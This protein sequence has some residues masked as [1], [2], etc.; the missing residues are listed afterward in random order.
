[1]KGKRKAARMRSSVM[2]IL[3]VL[4]TVLSI[5]GPALALSWD[6]TGVSSGGS[7]MTGSGGYVLYESEA[8]RATVA[9]RFSAIRADGSYTTGKLETSV[10]E[11][12]FNNESATSSNS[13]NAIKNKTIY[14]SETKYDKAAIVRNFLANDKTTVSLPFVT[15]QNDNQIV[16]EENIDTF[17]SDLPDD[18][19]A[20]GAWFAYQ[21]NADTVAKMLGYKSGTKEM[22]LG[23]TIIV[24]PVFQLV[25]ENQWH[26]LTVTEIAAYAGNK[27]GSFSNTV[28]TSSNSQSWGFICN[29]TNKHWPNALRTEENE[30]WWKNAPKLTDTTYGSRYNNA[31]FGTLIEKGYGVGILWETN[32]ITT[33]PD[34]GITPF[35]GTSYKIVFA[36]D[37][38]HIYDPYKLPK[39][40]DI[41]VIVQV[42]D[43]NSS[44]L[45]ESCYFYFEQRVHDER[46]PIMS[47]MKRGRIVTNYSIE[48]QAFVQELTGLSG[49]IWSLDEYAQANRTPHGDGAA[50]PVTADGLP[51]FWIDTINS[52]GL[53]PSNWSGDYGVA[54][55]TLDAVEPADIAALEYTDTNNGAVQSYR[56]VDDAISQS[57]I[58]ITDI[59]L[60]ASMSTEN[61]FPKDAG[62]VYKIPYGAK[63]YVLH[64]YKNHSSHTDWVRGFDKSTSST[65]TDR[66]EIAANSETDYVCA[67]RFIADHANAAGSNAFTAN[68]RTGYVY[69]SG[70]TSASH[71]SNTAN[72]SRSVQWK[73]DYDVAAFVIL[74]DAAG[75]MLG[76]SDS[77]KTIVVP[78]GQKVYVYL[79][80]RNYM[81]SSLIY[82]SGSSQSKLQISGY[83]GTTASTA[84]ANASKKTVTQS[85]TGDSN[86]LDIQYTSF[87]AAAGGSG[88]YSFS[89]RV[90]G[91][92][93]DSGMAYDRNTANNSATLNYTVAAP[94]TDISLDSIYYTTDAAGNNKFTGTP[95]FNVGT[96]IYIWYT[97]SVTTKQEFLGV[98]F[99]HD[100]ALAA[101]EWFGG[102]ATGKITA[103]TSMNIRTGPGSSY[104]KV[105][106]LA[107]GTT[108]RILHVVDTGTERWGEI[109]VDSTVA[110][111]FLSGYDAGDYKTVWMKLNTYVEETVD[112]SGCTLKGKN[113]Y[114]VMNVRTGPGTSYAADGTLAKG[115]E[116]TFTKTVRH[117]DGSIW[118][119]FGTNKWVRIQNANHG[120]VSMETTLTATKSVCVEKLAPGGTTTTTGD[121]G[122]Y[123]VSGAVY[124]TGTTSTKNETNGSNNT[125]TSSYTVENSEYTV[126]VIAGTGIRIVTGGSQYSPGDT[127]TVNTLPLTGYQ[128]ADWTDADGVRV[129]TDRKYTFTMPAHDV[130]LT[131]NAKTIGYRITY[132][133]NNEVG[134]S[135]T[136]RYS[137]ET[138]LTVLAAPSYPGHVF[139]GWEVTTAAGN[140]T[141]GTTYAAGEDIPAGKYG[142]VTLTAQWAPVYDVAITNIR[143]LYKEDDRLVEV[144]N[145]NM[146]YGKKIYVYYTVRNN[147]PVEVSVNIYNASGTRLNPSVITLARG[148]LGDGTAPSD[149]SHIKSV[150]A[151]SFVAGTIGQVTFGGSVYM[152]GYTNAD[153][154]TNT[155]NNTRSEAVKVKFDVALE[156]IYLGDSEGN[157][158]TS[159]IVPVGIK[160]YV[161]HVYRNN[162]YKD[163]V[164]DGYDDSG[165]QVASSVTVPARDTV[166]VKTYQITTPDQVDAYT[167]RGSVY[168]TGYSASTELYET[169]LANNIKTQSYETVALPYL[170][171]IAPN[172]D[173]RE[174][175]S[176]ITSY[177]LRNF[178]DTEYPGD[179]PIA[180]V[181]NV[182]SESGDLI[183]TVTK[184][185]VVP[186]NE[187]QLVYFKWDVPNFYNESTFVIKAYLDLPQYHPSAET[188]LNMLVSGNYGYR[189]WV[190]SITADTEYAD[191]QPPYWRRPSAPAESDI[192]AEWTVWEYIDGEF[193]QKT[194]GINAGI[195]NA[196]VTPDSKTAYVKYGKWR[197]KSGYGLKL[198]ISGLLTAIEGTDSDA[199]TAEQYVY[200]LFPE[201]KYRM[202]ANEFAALKYVNGSW[203]L[204]Q[205]KEYKNNRIHFT[206][207]WYPD[208][209]YTIQVIIEDIWTPNGMMTIKHNVTLVI[210]GDM[211]DDW[212]IQ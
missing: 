202:G 103:N 45:A 51:V 181:M 161:Y 102:T 6:G 133:P 199:Y 61:E 134:S 25:L 197:M 142:D 125:K 54:V 166:T 105:A 19:S 167:L 29:F 2:A 63:V 71:E 111:G 115:A 9:Y 112:Y 108:V 70:Y 18:P 81:D 157:R 74:K 201:Y 205:R 109:L 139:T 147:S 185:V 168:R 179:T 211:Y 150:F 104:T 208:G 27:F 97:A 110:A 188:Y 23:D 87:T 14:T 120:A 178:T 43:L 93:G 184:D 100:D 79:R 1:M 196:E 86:Y 49:A 171:A 36:D 113:V 22:N 137:I 158:I 194:Y 183:T 209:N 82:A 26:A 67:G 83:A 119:Q 58:A 84:I 144:T 186:A 55:T 62:G 68:T 17:Y 175:T 59:K 95:S 122:I 192:A 212:Y 193:V 21:E 169:D 182:Y 176:V 130:V 73:A 164:V 154:E 50:I 91:T 38:G 131:A 172:A 146:P 30:T 128:F 117:A 64:K 76:A 203:Q 33:K 56:F 118:G 16:L 98:D 155:T 10:L 5:A 191:S 20:I 46:D 96:S 177:W 153:H 8:K 204:P 149:N 170:E 152:N 159:N 198:D 121:I 145:E 37:K 210:E 206:P 207:I 126:T 127:V 78:N 75:N 129:S 57:D 53:D 42:K 200:A 12:W 34:L 195:E 47:A 99:R 72:N 162:S 80:I 140:W 143:F 3:L 31:P 39:N 4:A 138:D 180:V 151:E 106:S 60:S 69:Q 174:G 88:S 41:H 32:G 94:T 148:I 48:T 107:A 15:S 116:V 85:K 123:N 189:G 66:I 52:A 132:V 7:T 136:F 165:N 11:I 90:A 163:V 89:V 187:S 156:E 77:G 135:R 40:K 114:G 13:Y 141:A 160:L 44:V 24:E 65:P 101:A 190:D 173:Y 35:R 92:V 28:G 124:E